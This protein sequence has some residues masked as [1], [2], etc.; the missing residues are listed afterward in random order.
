MSGGVIYTE[1]R[2]RE[3]VNRPVPGGRGTGCQGMAPGRITTHG[4]RNGA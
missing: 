2:A 4:F 1:P 3:T